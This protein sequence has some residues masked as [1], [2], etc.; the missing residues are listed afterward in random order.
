MIKHIL[1]KEQAR[2]LAAPHLDGKEVDVTLKPENEK[3][4]LD[5]NVRVAKDIYLDGV[6]I[7]GN[8]SLDE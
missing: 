4:P 8:L 6:R 7:G 5:K 2:R 1:T 3:H